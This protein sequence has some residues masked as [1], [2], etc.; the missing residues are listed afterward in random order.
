MMFLSFLKSSNNIFLT[1]LFQRLQGT[2]L[3]LGSRKC[4]FAQRECVYLG[5]FIS[6]EVI[7]P[8]RDHVCAIQE[9]PPLK[10]VKELRRLIVYLMGTA[11]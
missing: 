2:S 11:I 8:S 7:Q 9:Y 4:N 6:K 10:Y 1:L 3:K 5:H